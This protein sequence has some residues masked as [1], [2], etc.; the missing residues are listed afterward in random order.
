MDCLVSIDGTWQ[1]RG[2]QSLLGAVYVIEYQTGKVLDYNIVF[3]KFCHNCNLHLIGT[4]V[5]QIS[6][7]GRNLTK[8]NVKVIFIVAQ[9][10]WS[11]WDLFRFS[12][13]L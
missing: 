13:V 2:H 8:A 11:P 9:V 10:L 1:K 4:K 6:W 3:C 5:L 12:N 7:R